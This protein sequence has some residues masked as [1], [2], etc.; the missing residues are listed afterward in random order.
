MEDNRGEVTLKLKYPVVVEEITI[1]HI[2]KAIIPDGFEKSAPKKIKVIGFPPCNED[3]TECLSLGFDETDPMDIADFT[4]EL[5]GPSVQSFHSHYGRAM[6][7]L[8]ATQASV[9]TEESD[10]PASCSS[11]AA[12]CTTPPRISVAGVHVRVLENWGNKKYTCLYRVRIHGEAD[13]Y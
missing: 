12:S 10:D 13:D 7:E 5:D 6:K 1:D 8:E 11:E 9:E 2:S 3:D 4:F